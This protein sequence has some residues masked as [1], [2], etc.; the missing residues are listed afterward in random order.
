MDKEKVLD[1][2]KL[3]RISISEEEAENLSSEF[4]DILRYVD[5]INK[6]EIDAHE[7]GYSDNPLKNVFRED[8]PTNTS[9]ENTEVI[10]QNS[11]QREGNYIKVKNIL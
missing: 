9:G 1:L 4:D 5:E 6:A 11:P 2:A 8:N 3:A 10:L 7:G